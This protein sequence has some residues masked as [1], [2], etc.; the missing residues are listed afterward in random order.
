MSRGQRGGSPTV[1]NLSF[2]DRKS[3][4]TS[5]TKS[6]YNSDCGSLELNPS[7]PTRTSALLE[8]SLFVTHNLVFRELT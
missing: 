7:G 8:L 3:H 4:S 2:L 6:R 1:F 5:L